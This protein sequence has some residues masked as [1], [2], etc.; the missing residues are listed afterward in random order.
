[1]AGSTPV[2]TVISGWVHGDLGPVDEKAIPV[3]LGDFDRT[4][5]SVHEMIQVAGALDVDRLELDRDRTPDFLAVGDDSL[6]QSSKVG[7]R[8]V[9]N[10]EVKWV[11]KSG[12]GGAFPRD[13]DGFRDSA[14]YVRPV[15]TKTGGPSPPC[16][17]IPVKGTADAP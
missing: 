6:S 3:A 12:A 11:P 7:G 14:V 17:R 8:K 10:L 1:M 4:K 16:L 13:E 5:E 9:W 15:Y 2:Q